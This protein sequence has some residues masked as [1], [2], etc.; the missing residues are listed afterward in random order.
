MLNLRNGKWLINC[1]YNANKTRTCNHLDALSTYLNLQSTTYEKILILGDFNVGIEEQHIKA[2]CDNYN[3][4]SLIKQ[5]TCYKNPNNLTCIDLILYNTLR[6]FQSTCVIG[7]GLSDFH[8][9]TVTA[10]KKSFRKFHSRL[11]N[12]RSHK[13]FSNE[14]FRECL[15]EK[16]SKEIFENNDEGLR[17]FCDINL[18]VLNQHAP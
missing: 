3:L 9:M 16:L 12:Y 18:Q 11:I 15:L 6:S 10:M 1:S 2:F 7:T 8:L 17:R 14:A 5:P 4:T 13:N